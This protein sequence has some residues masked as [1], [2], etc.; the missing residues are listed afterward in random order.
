MGTVSSWNMRSVLF[1]CIRKSGRWK[2]RCKACLTCHAYPQWL[3]LFCK[4]MRLHED[5]FKLSKHET[6]S[7]M[8]FKTVSKNTTYYYHYHYHS[9]PPLDTTTAERGAATPYHTF[10]HSLLSLLR[11]PPQFGKLK[12]K[13]SPSPAKWWSHVKSQAMSWSPTIE[14][15]KSGHAELDSFM[16]FLVILLLFT[17][18]GKIQQEYWGELMWTIM[19]NWQ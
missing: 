11:A 16:A 19:N 18:F 12:K 6:S 3:G 10:T 5:S 8:S 1:W 4:L 14:L 7:L 15:V 9:P 13:S 2:A 17:V